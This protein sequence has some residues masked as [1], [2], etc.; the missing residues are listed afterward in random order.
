MVD[1]LN[2][3]KMPLEPPIGELHHPVPL[4]LVPFQA[5]I[6]YGT[7]WWWTFWLEPTHNA[8]RSKS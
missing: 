3:A 1:V 2:A 4:A 6:S 7:P 8:M 5:S